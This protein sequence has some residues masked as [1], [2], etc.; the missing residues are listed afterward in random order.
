M[1]TE[2]EGK[3]TLF[4]PQDPVAEENSTILIIPLQLL[5]LLWTSLLYSSSLLLC[6]PSLFGT[7]TSAG[8]FDQRATRT[9]FLSG[10]SDKTYALSTSLA[11]I[12][13]LNLL[14]V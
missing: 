7:I 14:V 5:C 4:T 11:P 13:Q 12:K 9:L 1:E 3:A 2:E 8:G 6:A 10:E